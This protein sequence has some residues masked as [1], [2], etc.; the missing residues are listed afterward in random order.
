MQGG[1]SGCSRLFLQGLALLLVA[2]V[3]MH[4][5]PRRTRAARKVLE[6]AACP[7]RRAAHH[8]ELGA[9]IE[10]AAALLRLVDG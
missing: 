3:P 2:A 1:R 8:K 6:L 5:L 4:R 7:M 9:S 10:V